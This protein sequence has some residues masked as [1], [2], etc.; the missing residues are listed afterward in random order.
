M[1][2]DLD[3]S[4]C[5]RALIARDQRFDGQFFVGVSST[6]IYCR[7]VCRVRTPKA[8]NCSFFSTAAAAEGWGFR[9]CLK[10]R[11]ELAPSQSAIASGASLAAAAARLIEA[12]EVDSLAH[13][14][15]QV[16]VTDRHLRRL[17]EAEFGVTP[18][19]YQQTQRLLLAKRLLTDTTLPVADVACAAGFGSTRRLNELLKDRY[20]LAPSNFRRVGVKSMSAPREP[21]QFTLAVRPPYAWGATLAFL[22]KRAISGVES[23]ADGRYTRSLS[24]ADGKRT[25][26]GRVSVTM[27]REDALTL[28]MSDALLPVLPQVLARLRRLFDCEADPIAITETLGPLAREPGLRLPGAADGFEVAVRAILGQQ[29][30]VKAAITL[31]GRVVAAFGDPLASDSG[32]VSVTH[33]FPP[34]QK[35]AAATQDDIAKLGII[36][37]RANAIIAVARAV[38]EGSIALHPGAGFAATEAALVALPGIGEWT[39]QYICMRALGWPDV[40]LSG[41]LGVRKAMGMMTPREAL[42]QA[43]RWRPYRAYAVMHLWQQQASQSASLKSGVN[44]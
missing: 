4:V 31:A 27:L 23:V 36:A 22:A 30:T 15:L 38:A 1:F 44:T 13:L 6:G 7:P 8:A 12:G 43:E 41:D 10:C 25:L 11:P 20:G 40:F 35:L 14:A 37:S 28:T 16:G 5:Y 9:P 42:A 17:F 3:P 19:A 39:A 29:V 18:V 34:P 24:L 32:S 33:T 21:L 26:R 2:A